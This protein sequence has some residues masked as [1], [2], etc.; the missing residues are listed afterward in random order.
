MVAGFA[1]FHGHAH[2]AEASG[3][4]PLYMAGFAVSTL[5]LHL[6]AI[7]LAGALAR[8]R[9]ALPALG[10]SIAASGAVMLAG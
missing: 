7:G 10:L 8:L 5:L 1:L 9:H 2:G 3:A 6:G 4:L